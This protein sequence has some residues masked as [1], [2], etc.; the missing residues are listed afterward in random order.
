[1]GNQITKNNHYVPQFYLRNWSQ[2]GKT[3]LTYR[4][5]VSSSSV[6]MWEP[7]SI[8]RVASHQHLYTIEV[9]G[10]PSDEIEKWFNSNFETPAQP[11]IEK[12]VAGK[13][14]SREDYQLLV[15][16]LVVQMVRTPSWNNYLVNK[17]TEL[18]P[19]TLESVGKKLEAILKNKETLPPVAPLVEP[20]PFQIHVQ[21]STGDS[22]NISYIEAEMFIGQK[23]WLAEIKRLL[24][25]IIPVLNH[26][27]WC[28][29]EAAPGVDFPTSD[30]P[31]VRVGFRSSDNY[32]FEGVGANQPN[33]NIFLPL[34][35]KHLLYTKVGKSQK[36]RQ[37]DAE[38]SNLLRQLIISHADRHVFSTSVI[39]GISAFKPRIVNAELFKAEQTAWNNWHE[40]QREA[41][42]DWD[43]SDMT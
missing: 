17:A 21:F 42:R 23:M 12:V 39:K 33:A 5:L 18:F 7:L 16:F 3:V 32:W 35:P 8:E 29:L 14:L 40:S 4:T 24:P 34:S 30:D 36:S 38:K 6:P 11:A 1:M 13:H 2:D 31:V 9:N 43:S 41:E 20:N 27:S 25:R 10:Q 19:K 26:H 15:K 22:T 37:L 28:I